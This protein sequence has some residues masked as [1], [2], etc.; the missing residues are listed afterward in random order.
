MPAIY[1]SAFRNIQSVLKLEVLALIGDAIS[2]CDRNKLSIVTKG[3]KTARSD[4][5]VQILICS[6]LFEKLVVRID[7]RD[8][9]LRNAARLDATLSLYKVIERVS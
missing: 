1:I 5:A 6:L 4:G 3:S 8:F 2:R 7:A 9:P